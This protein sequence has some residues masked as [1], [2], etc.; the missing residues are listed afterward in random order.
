[1]LVEIKQVK[2]FKDEGYRRWFMDRYFDLIVWYDD[3]G[4]IKGF[5]MCYDKDNME[6]SLTWNQKGGFQ[7]N[8]IDSG[9]K[10]GHAK[11]TPILVSDGLFS[12]NEIAERFKKESKKIDKK[13]AAFVYEKILTYQ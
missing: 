13:V 12:K 9:E 4:K 10:P 2:Q 8:K 5:Q 7:H 11:M 3:Y 6:R 1:V